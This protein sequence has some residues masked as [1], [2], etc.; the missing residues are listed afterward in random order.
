MNFLAEP[1]QGPASDLAALGRRGDLRISSGGGAETQSAG[2][3]LTKDSLLTYFGGA[4]QQTPHLHLILWGSNWTKAGQSQEVRQAMELL[5]NGLSGSAYQGL[6]TQYF[7][8][9]LKESD[10]HPNPISG[11]VVFSASADI[12]I[13]SS[14]AAPTNVGHGTI[15]QEIAKAKAA[16]GWSSQIEDQY[17]VLPA[18]GSSYQANFIGSFCAYHET[19]EGSPYTLLL[20]PGANADCGSTPK[21]ITRYA[22]HE[23]AESVTDPFPYTAWSIPVT[24][25]NGTLLGM[26]EIGDYCELQASQQLSNGASVRPDQGRL[27]NDL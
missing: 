9:P 20:P 24:N 5:F 19:S 26:V 15:Y 27:Q 7:A 2:G 4:V 21:S 10:P 13:D 14:V 8:N 6:M 18:I 16:K 25:K 3:G 17:F 12:Y 23:Y 11:S 1:G 22:S